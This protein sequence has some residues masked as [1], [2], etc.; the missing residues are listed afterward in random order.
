MSDIELGDG[1]QTDDFASDDLLSKTIL[2]FC[3]K[4][5]KNIPITLV[6]NGDS[7]DFIRSSYKEK[8][9]R[10]I[11]TEVSLWKLERIYQ[12]HKKVFDSYKK[13]SSIKKNTLVFVLGN[14]DMDVAFKDV[15]KKLRE[16][17]NK[18]VQFPGFSY[19]KSSVH[20]EH[21]SQYDSLF[22]INPRRIFIDYNG[23]K[24]LNLP[25][26]T[27]GLFEYYMQYKVRY[28]MLD[29]IYP[30]NLI[31]QKYSKL[32]KELNFGAFKYLIK[33]AV[34]NQVRYYHDLTYRLSFKTMFNYLKR[35]LQNNYELLF[36]DQLKEVLATDNKI[37]VV[38]A[39]HSHEA[40]LQRK[41]GGYFVNTGTWREEYFVSSDGGSVTVKYKT[42]VEIHLKE[43]IVN[44][45]LLHAVKKEV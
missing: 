30:R 3:S 45:V 33:T 11:T 20:F 36:E 21:G 41:K 19:D 23:K 29:R 40:K 6:V 8:Y 31:L 38:V 35:L 34:I 28:P 7:F 18:S 2:G 27:Y 44:K 24:I 39:G 12:A 5:Y 22:Y 10:Y 43:D 42:Y 17:I 26:M 9:P 14:H 16:Y 37:K 25:W 15:Q 13:F 4:K 32:V 1:S